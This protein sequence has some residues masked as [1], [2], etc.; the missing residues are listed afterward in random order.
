[1]ATIN[2]KIKEEKTTG[3][4]EKNKIKIKIEEN[5][6]SHEEYTH[7][8]E[9]IENP[10]VKQEQQQQEVLNKQVKQ[11]KE[12][13]VQEEVSNKQVKKWFC[14]AA[15]ASA[16]NKCCMKVWT[17]VSNYYK[18]KIKKKNHMVKKFQRAEMA[19][20]KVFIKM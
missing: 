14:E 17:G 3:E 4:V 15:A 1:M 8:Q 19:K 9:Y 5:P 10:D 11:E 16:Q 12:E 6:P 18:Y 7:S 13:Q 2:I 20:A